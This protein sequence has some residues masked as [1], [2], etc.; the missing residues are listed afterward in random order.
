MSSLEKILVLSSEDKDSPTDSNSDFTVTLKE[1]YYTQNVLRI[2]VKEITVPNTFPNIRGTAYGSSQNNILTL[3]RA[4]AT[5]FPVTMPEGQYLI[6][7]ADPLVDFATVLKPLIDAATGDVVTITF[8]DLTGTLTLAFAASTYKIYAA[9]N[10]S[11]INTPMSDPLGFSVEQGYLATLVGDSMV[12][13]AGY[14]NVYVHS[15]EIAEAHGIDGD[16]GLI[17][18][19]DPINLSDAAYGSYAYKKNDDDELSSIAY[20][21]IRNLSRVRIVLRDNKGNKLPIGTHSLNLTLK[22]YLASG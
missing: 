11:S 6:N 1:S 13:L 16:A 18:L 4:D 19:V 2:L 15:K 22:I 20:E 3:E 14:Q 10:S 17:A 21:D 9:E 8:S 5:L 7:S 12:D